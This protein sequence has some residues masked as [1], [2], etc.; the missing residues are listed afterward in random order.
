MDTNNNYKDFTEKFYEVEE[1]TDTFRDL[2]WGSSE[3][4]KIRF[5]YL[6]KLFEEDTKEISLLD[7][8][9]GLA[10]FYNYISENN[11]V[12][13]QYS[14]LDIQPN[15][16][17]FA[18]KK[19][20]ECDFINKSLFELETKKKYD[21]VVASGTFNIVLPNTNMDDYL[22][23]NIKKMYELCNKGIAFNLLTTNTPS[24]DMESINAC[25]NPIDILKL[26]FGFTNKVNLYHSY[27]INDFTIVMYK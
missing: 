17:K 6:T 19:F 4:Q 18:S 25:Y 26:C 12:N 15:F 14:G 23:Q 11:F 9:C 24:H 13:V 20:P 22:K 7:V 21:Y 8:G 27:K 3:S 16:I 2:Q 5:Q 1:I 10:H